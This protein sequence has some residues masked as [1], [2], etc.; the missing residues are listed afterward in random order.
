[1]LIVVI[2]LVLVTV[3]AMTFAVAMFFDQRS[4]QARLLRERLAS[5]ERALEREPSPELALLR[6][7]MLSQIPAIDNLLRRSE[8]MTNVHHFLEQAKLKVRAA[9]RKSGPGD[10]T[11]GRGK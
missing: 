2:V 7:E 4:A 5:V 9:L 6:D 8:R 11:S 10:R 1:M 3:A